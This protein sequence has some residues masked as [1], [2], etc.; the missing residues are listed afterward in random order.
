[1]IERSLP[2]SN[3]ATVRAVEGPAVALVLQPEAEV[4]EPPLIIG[5]EAQAKLDGQA[6]RNGTA[7]RL[8]Q[9]HTRPRL[10]QFRQKEQ[11]LTAAYEGYGCPTTH[12]G[13]AC[14]CK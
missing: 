4:E 2:S 6:L 11:V 7:L 12:A 14:L 9:M 10:L 8:A 13:R 3:T 1:M 5:T